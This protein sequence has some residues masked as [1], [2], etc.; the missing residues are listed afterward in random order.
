MQTT[1]TKKIIRRTSKARRTIVRK[2]V[3]KRQDG[4]TETGGDE[5]AGSGPSIHLLTKDL[6]P[7]TQLELGLQAG[8]DD[9]EL[10]CLL[11]IVDTE[12]KMLQAIEDLYLIVKAQPRYKN[13]KDPD[14]KENANPVTI[15]LWVL[16]KLGPLAKGKSWT[17]DTYQEGKKTRYRF[18]VYCRFHSQRLQDR[19]EHISLDFLPGLRKRD[20]PLHD[21]IIDV[22]ALTSRE[23]K[24]PLW[25][26][27]G[28]FSKAKEEFLS[29][30]TK[31]TI[32]NNLLDTQ[33]YSYT[34]GPAALYLRYI[35]QRRKIVTVASIRKRLIEYDNNSQRKC[36]MTYWV[37]H[38]I[39]IAVSKK[40]VDQFTFVP[41]FLKASNPITPF[42]L[43]KYVWS[44]HDHDIVKVRAYDQMKKD[45][46][47][48][49]FVPVM[50]AVTKPGQ[51]AT[52]VND[53]DWP[54]ELYDFMRSIISHTRWTYKQY[55]YKDQLEDRATPMDT[56]LE[57][58]EKA[59]IKN[60]FKNE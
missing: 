54:E 49:F 3:G 15:L 47:K 6:K 30:E 45:T 59:E 60:W 9:H 12:E 21:L 50:F 31:R 51:V 13:L 1:K 5:S 53:D 8:N 57:T 27:D 48:G 56:L 26:E 44:M 28:D 10:Q 41:N 36:F 20:K 43:Y 46:K 37:R 52:E 18:V 55:Y 39:D 42:R 23:N 32:Y 7:I 35:K 19:E 14:W 40:N 11:R 58:I 16:R 38:G 2:N 4:N 17:V 29:G 24:I 34:S 25:D 33:K 22:V